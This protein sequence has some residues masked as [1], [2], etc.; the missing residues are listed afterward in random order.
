MF[1]D[2][3]I[4]HLKINYIFYIGV[5]IILYFLS[6]KLNT[7]FLTLIYSFIFAGIT[8][9]FV[10]VF[11][12]KFSFEDMYSEEFKNYYNIVDG[13]M[14]D[15]ISKDFIYIS[16]FHRKIHHNTDENKKYK[17]LLIEFIENFTTQGLIPIFV[18]FLSKFVNYWIFI[19]WGLTY[20]TIHIF[21]YNIYPCKIHEQHHINSNSNLGIDL[22]D[23]LFNSKFN[24]EIENINHYLFN[25]LIIGLFIY[26]LNL[27]K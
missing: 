24:N 1:K 10:H 3:I 9:Y 22:Y 14:F 15:I 20:A 6:K 18:I 26:I 7:T 27:K 13:S 5:I 2:Y 19:L 4:K 23:I 12:H 11:S 21:N 25:Y 16:D 8:G 17:N